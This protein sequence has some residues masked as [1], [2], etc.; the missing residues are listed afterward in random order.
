[1]QADQKIYIAGTGMITS[2]GANTAMTIASVRAGVDGFEA[3]EYTTP[4]QQPITMAQVPHEVF[5]D[6]AIELDIGVAHGELM[7]REI[8]MAMIAAAEALQQAAVT[9]PLP[10]ILA[11]QEEVPYVSHCPAGK[12]LTNLI[13]QAE[14]PIDPELSRSVRSGRAGAIEALDLAQ[15]CLYDLQ[16]DYVLVGGSDSH[17]DYALL[18]YLN[19]LNRTTAP[20]VLDGF[21]PGEAAGF[22]LLTRQ[23]QLALQQDGCIIALNPVGLCQESGHFYS[24]VPCLGNGLSEAF[25]R[26]L[27][28]YQGSAIDTIYASM[29]GENYW[30]KE[31]GVACLRNSKNLHEDFAVEHPA[32]C[33]GDIGVAT[34]PVLISLAADH[35][36]RAP[37]SNACL[38]YTSSDTASRSA[39]VAEKLGF[40]QSFS[41]EVS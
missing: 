6:F 3:S 32:D 19:E 35:L 5:A 21:I 2:I 38:I 4:K 25:R 23:P 31:Y 13:N 12:M 40:N 10:L 30:A 39:V 14:L 29:N 28:A 20:E 34:G 7:D 8:K 18:N 16:L 17:R 9:Q 22:L 1:M 15:R 24:D 11:T 33:Y 41:G 26:A 36:Q 37:G 27:A